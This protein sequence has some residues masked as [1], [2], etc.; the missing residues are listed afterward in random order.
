MK[1][2][3]LIKYKEENKE[4]QFDEIIKN[5]ENVIKEID[6]KSDKKN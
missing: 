2:K 6:T 1:F 4:K 3:E 5:N